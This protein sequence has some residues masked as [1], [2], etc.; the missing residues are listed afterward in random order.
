MT[1]RRKVL[2]V[3]G[4]AVVL[5]VLV[6]VNLRSRGSAVEVQV[7]EVGRRD[8]SRV[9]T[10]SGEIHP[11]RRVNVSANAI[12]KVTR[13]A[14]KEGDRVRK[15][16]FLLEIDAEPYESAV[17]QLTA[18]VRG[19][20]AALDMEKASLTKAQDD[21]ERAQQLHEKGFMSD[22]EFKTATSTLE[23]A[24]ARQR[25]A[26]ETLAQAEANLRKATHELRNVHITAEMSGVI[27]ALNVEE[28]ES[29]IMGTLNNPGT[30]LLTIADLSEI[31][32]EV[33]V[34]ETEVVLVRTGQAAEV[35][36]DAHP[37]TTYHGVVTEVGNSAIR[38]QVGMG[39]E[40]VDFKVV[41]A[42]RD[43]IPDVRP[44]LSASVD[45]TVA[46]VDD[47]LAIPIQCLTVRDQ[48][49]LDRERRRGRGGNGAPAADS[50][51]TGAEEARRDIEGVFVVENGIA[52]F[53]EVRVGIAGQSH[54]EVQ[55]GLQE[56]ATV[57]SGP[58]KTISDLVDRSRVK[59]QKDRTRR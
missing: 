6:G 42:I 31:E 4:G 58:F 30:V 28:G 59:V 55:G 21:Y 51:V 41:V 20:R 11:R 13:L 16:D 23:V 15:G 29:A 48:E 46:H 22:G 52:T 9:I 38:A 34:D 8:I 56:G 18:A 14:V 19:A 43:S 39:Q 3:A 40:S 1:R 26:T 12:G 33:R 57:V 25:N 36:L 5:A 27:T 45:I 47:A 54:F 7:T 53:R 50:S 24:Q 49:R 2:L 10:A 17:D 35:R 37:D 44:G 32:A